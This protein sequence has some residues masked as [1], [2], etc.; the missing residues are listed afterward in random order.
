M[1]QKYYFVLSIEEWRLMI[2]CLKNFPNRLI[3]E[4]KY[5]DTVDEVLI[6]VANARRIRRPHT[7]RYSTHS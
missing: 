5:I 6:K 1:K 7:R 2:H 4:G 3:L